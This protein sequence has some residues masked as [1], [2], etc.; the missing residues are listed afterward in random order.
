[1]LNMHDDNGA[2]SHDLVAGHRSLFQA[3]RSS[4]Q[5]AES[6]DAQRDE[7]HDPPR[8]SLP[9]HVVQ[10]DKAQ[11]QEQTTSKFFTRLN[12]TLAALLIF[13]VLAVV[14]AV[15]LTSDGSSPPAQEAQV[16]ATGA[17]GSHD[18]DQIFIR[19]I[20]DHKVLSGKEPQMF[21]TPT[22]TPTTAPTMTELDRRFIERSI[23]DDSAIK[24]CISTVASDPRIMQELIHQLLANQEARALI[25]AKLVE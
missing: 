16:Q 5:N 8:S 9:T 15:V 18:N 25:A 17:K 24:R 1:M 19:S 3:F 13:A 4:G 10:R 21:N 6:A 2:S 7:S 20:K 23:D 22:T 11:E 14:L 12:K